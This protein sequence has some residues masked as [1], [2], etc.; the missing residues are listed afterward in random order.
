MELLKTIR[1][2]AAFLRAYVALTRDPGQL[3]VVFSLRDALDDPKVIG[4]VAT[5]LRRDPHLARALDERPRLP[6][7]ALEELARLPAGSLGRTFADEMRAR[8]LDPAAL[9]RMEA[10]DEIGYFPAHLYETHDLWHTVTGFETDV[11][12]ELGLQAFYAAQLGGPLPYAILSAGLLNTVI[13]GMDDR[14]RRL[15]AVGRGWLLGRR[16]RPLFGVRW[17]EHLAR[18]LSEVRASLGQPE[19]PQRGTHC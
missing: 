1:R 2:N 19:E 11:A 13:S 16:A 17:A 15:D 9:P 3:G 14:D 18:P 8:G 10:H 12:G 4:E 5:A 7:L 6:P